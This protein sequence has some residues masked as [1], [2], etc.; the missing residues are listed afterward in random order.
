MFELDIRSA[1][2]N[3]RVHVDT[4]FQKQESNFDFLIIDDFFQGMFSDLSTPIYWVTC[5]ETNKTLGEVDA[6][7]EAMKLAG[8]RRDSR[9]AAVGGGVI[10][11]L[12]TLTASLYMRGITWSYFPTTL[13]GMIDSCLGG[14]SSINVGGT[15]NLVGN[16]YPPNEIFID[17]QFAT[18]LPTPALISG[19]AE[20]VKICFA[21]GPVSFSNF[22]S[23]PACLNN[24]VSKNFGKLIFETLSCKKWFIEK[25]EFDL[26]ERQLLNF[27]HSFGHA[28]E[29]G[30]NFQ[31]QH[32]VAVAIG[33]LAALLHPHST[34]SEATEILQKYILQLLA[35]LEKE[36]NSMAEEVDWEVFK[37]ALA[38]DKKNTKTELCLILPSS[39]EALEKVS[40]PFSDGAI[41]TA[42]ESLVNALQIITTAGAK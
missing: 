25:D 12:A 26:K 40:L 16:V 14:K 15:K 11:D 39:K 35:P 37:L 34:Q 18:S 41:D 4:E 22:L 6:I 31:I 38:S 21:R 42:T 27:G 28:L 29:A 32:G 3:Y 2:E 5:L 19:L 7:C 24:G 13:T 8:V 36:L 10:Q 33:M 9:I 30:C 17:L 1:L 20:A 23:N